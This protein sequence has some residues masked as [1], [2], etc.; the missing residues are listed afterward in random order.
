MSY[1]EIWFPGRVEKSKS[2]HAAACVPS[3]RPGK[4][5][6]YHRPQVYTSSSMTDSQK[7][8][9]IDY[10]KQQWGLP[11]IQHFI[12][13]QFLF[14]VSEYPTTRTFDMS[15]CY[16]GIEDLIQT[17]QWKTNKATQEKYFK[18]GG[19]GII[20]NDGL[21][22]GHNGSDF[23]YLCPECEWGET[24]TRKKSTKNHERCPKKAK[25]GNFAGVPCPY[26]GTLLIITDYI[27][28]RMT[29]DWIERV[30][31]KTKNE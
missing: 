10:I 16:Q 8:T 19:V 30:F 1:P 26:E 5:K 6:C 22:H 20:E 4:K 27:L 29:Q 23:K 31:K 25:R 24:G 12:N 7:N 9:L 11:P 18:S 15:N 21:I 3:G 2:K 13:A 14:F 28:N 17:P